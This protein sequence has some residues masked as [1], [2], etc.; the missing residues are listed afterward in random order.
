MPVVS[1]V[2]SKV[3]PLEDLLSVKQAARVLGLSVKTLRTWILHHQ[4][5]IVKVGSRVMF[6]Q[7]TLREFIDR[8]TV[9]PVD[10]AA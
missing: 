5:E 4:I 6:K 1:F 2:G 9:K 10:S 3:P 7:S 8:N